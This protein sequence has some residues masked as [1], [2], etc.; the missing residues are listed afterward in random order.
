MK[1][2]KEY[3]DDHQIKIST[4]VETDPWEKAKYQAAKRLAKRVKIPGFRPGKAPYNVILRTVGESAV[5][6][7]ALELLIED[8]YPK[9]LDEAEIEPY[10]PGTLDEVKSFDPPT[11]DFI[12]PLK[13]V[14]ELGDYKSLELAYEFP[15][16]GEEEIDQALENL[17]KQLA[18]NEPVDRPSDDGDVVYMRVSARRLDL[19]DAEAAQIYDQQFSSA[20]LGQD[21]SATD[22]QFFEGFAAK[23]VGMS[24]DEEKTFT[25]TYPEDYE[26][27]DLRGVEVEFKVLVTNVQ[28]YLLPELDDELAKTA[29]DFDTLEELRADIRKHLEEQ[30]KEN[31]QDDYENQVIDHLIEVSTV[32]YPPQAIEDEK[33]NMISNLEYRLSQQGLSL[34]LYKQFRSVGEEDF[35]KEIAETAEK[36]IKRELVLYQVAEAE[37]IQ[38]DQKELSDTTGRAIDNVTAQMTPKEI[39]DLQRDGRL[40]HMVNNIA[41]DM[42]F[43][44]AVEYICAIAKGEPLPVAAAADQTEA[45]EATP[46][47]ESAPE[48]AD[49]TPT[50]DNV[51]SESNKEKSEDA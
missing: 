41:T 19:E 27:E 32:K 47:G 21:G 26:D 31:Y 16:V 51:E 2:E 3:L 35:D 37:E 50:S 15:E 36:N 5:T 34:D 43:R 46:D 8:I 4:V 45:G 9:M 40:F 18:L 12:V 10:G 39:K 28:G 42:M 48:E 20:R 17:R 13:P 14:V 44:K 1:I 22:R 25:H 30:A 6:E 38:P 23:I 7:E 24:T 33:K 49:P 11:F 29:S